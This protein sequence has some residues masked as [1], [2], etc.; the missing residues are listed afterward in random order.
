MF[1]PI[2]LVGLVAFFLSIVLTPACRDL[3]R[4]L[5]IV[6]RPD[7][8]RKLHTQP[9]PLMGGVPIALSYV[10]SFLVL[11]L[12]PKEAVPFHFADVLRVVPAG[13]I[14]F[15]TG[16]VDDLLGLKP[17]QK[18]CGQALGAAWAFWAG[19]RIAS[20][21]GHNVGWASFLVTIVWLIGCTNAFNLID[22]VD[23]LAS[24]V[25]LFATATML[26]AA[27]LQHNN[28]VLALA[29]APLAGALL[30]FLRYNFNPASIFL[31]DSGSLTIGFLLGSFGVVWSQKSATILGMT[32]P[33]MA[34][35]IPIL[36]ASLSIVRRFLRNQPIFAGDRDHIH[37]R[38]L[39]RGFAPRRVVLTLYG[40]AS[41]G[42]AL[43]LLSVASNRLG[44]VIVLVFCAA[45]WLGI[46]H[47]GYL[48]FSTARRMLLAGTFQQALDAQLRLRA[49]EQELSAARSIGECWESILETSSQFDF[50]EVRL[51]IADTIYHKRLRDTNGDLCWSLRVPLPSGGY[52][53]FVRPHESAV[54]S[55]GVAPFIDVVRKTL[56][57]KSEEFGEPAA[58]VPAESPGRDYVSGRGRYLTAS[59]SPGVDR[60]GGVIE[61][62]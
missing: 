8:D 34:L 28:T 33:M 46:Q 1:Y 4:H 49:F 37:H 25:G 52:I 47:L 11:L 44:G 41:I 32:A 17:W 20:V 62:T 55:M 36:D 45:A 61:R 9:V 26:I 27:L 12:F 22:G 40:M 13:L 56:S 23:G 29:I 10:A 59:H 19:V 3:F 35:G 21:A 48:E 38:L 60:S 58:I 15:F 42:A 14:V 53:N 43:S 18:L 16:I 51:S 31:G 57:A 50:V 7:Q 6:D 30:A 39:K 2:F 5:G 54:L 24:G